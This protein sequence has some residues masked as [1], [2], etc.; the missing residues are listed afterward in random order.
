MKADSRFLDLIERIQGGHLMT[1]EECAY[2]IG[3]D[4]TSLEASIMRGVADTM[5]RAKFGNK[6]L[7]FGQ[8]G[9]DVMPCSGRCSF[10]SFSEEFT[11]FEKFSM[12]KED[13]ISKA[14][15][16]TESGELFALSL[17]VMHNTSF[18]R[19][20]DVI[21]TIRKTIPA[22]TKIM[23]NLGDFGATQAQE[24]KAAG[25]D[26]VYHVIRLG[27]GK[28]T[29]FTEEQ[30]FRTI[31]N[32]KEA[33]LKLFYCLEPIGPEHN[34][35]EMADQL[36][37]GVEMECYQHGAMRRV[38][39]PDSPLAKYGQI[40]ELRL[41]QLTAV[42]TMAALHSP[43]IVSVGVHE[44]NKLGITAGA[45]AI[46]AETGANPRDTELETSGHHGL[47]IQDCKNMFLECGFDL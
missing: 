16:F 38:L 43:E 4:E 13:M 1:R 32:A 14:V 33:G 8:I 6:G 40:S 27:E 45:N 36:L 41:A 2:L 21:S 34:P 9:V 18:D 46:Y 26:G 20:L 31:E 3:F 30:R 37:K 7:V 28:D 44:P 39:I 42:V 24:L 29:L 19:T 5:S 35:E 12:S 10:C 17:M 25:A 22:Q 23:A 11:K 15:N 47:D